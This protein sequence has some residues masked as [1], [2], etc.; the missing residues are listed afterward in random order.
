MITMH[1]HIHYDS[2]GISIETYWLASGVT[3]LA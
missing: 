1:A 2:L 3:L